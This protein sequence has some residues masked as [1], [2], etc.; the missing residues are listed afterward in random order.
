MNNFLVP[1]SWWVLAEVLLAAPIMY[2]LIIAYVRVFGKRSTSQ[3]N[4]FDW[5]VTVG[6]GS[7]FASTIII[8]DISLIVGA[9]SILLLLLLQYLLTWSLTASEKLRTL[10]KATPQLLLLRG[11]FISENMRT[12]RITRS[13][14][15]AAIRQK[16]YKSTQD[17]FAVVLETNAIL[18]IIPNDGND[19][20]PFCLSDVNGLPDD[21]KSD[22]ENRG[23]DKDV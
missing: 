5:I 6:M 1:D 14:V 20:K 13:E 11:E 8:E 21:L 23:Q 15:L 16:G 17:I 19:G 12:E 9:L 4:S 18:S 22:L 3:M 10:L 2:V 7:V